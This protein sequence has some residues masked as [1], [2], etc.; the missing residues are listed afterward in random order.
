MGEKSRG[1]T[2]LKLPI[3]YLA[4]G[5]IPSTHVGSGLFN[6]LCGILTNKRRLVPIAGDRGKSACL[7]VAEIHRI[8]H[9]ETEY[10]GCS[11]SRNRKNTSPPQKKIGGARKDSK[12][13]LCRNA[14]TTIL[15]MS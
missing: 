3:R 6:L 15:C 12:E 13:T 9:G 10:A 1:R 7:Q 4:Q 8:Q 2:P 14:P 11:F 5:E